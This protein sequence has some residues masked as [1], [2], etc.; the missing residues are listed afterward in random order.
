MRI[1]LLAGVLAAALSTVA[2]AA[3][4]EA[5]GR[6]DYP[7]IDRVQFVE[8]CVREHPDRAR[9]EMLYKCSCA[10]DKIIAQL[11]YEDYVEASTAYF[12]GQ[13]AGERGAGVRESTVGHTLADRYRAA[14]REAMKACLI[15][16]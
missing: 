3:E 1:H 2:T 9:Q 11:P 7:T 10:M 6:A 8:F 15:S 12:A 16:Q 13:I 4:D 5:L 14:H